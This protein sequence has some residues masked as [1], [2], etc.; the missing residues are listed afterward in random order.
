MVD[1]EHGRHRPGRRR[2]RGAARASCTTCSTTGGSRSSRASRPTRRPGPQRQRRHRGGRARRRAG[3]REARRAHRRRGAL[4]GLAGERRGRSPRSRASELTRAAADA[5]ARDGP[6]D[7]GVPAG[8]RAAASRARTSSTAGCRTR[9]CSRSSPTRASARW[10]SRHDRCGARDASPTSLV[11][12]PTADRRAAWTQ[13]YADSLMNTYG[14]PQ[15]VLVRGEGCYVW[16]ADGN[17]LPR[18]ARRHRGQRARPRPPGR[19]SSA[20]TAQVG[21]LGHV[22]N[23]FATPAADRAGRAAARRSLGAADGRVFFS[24]SGAEANEAAFKLAPARPA[25]PRSSRPRARSTAARW[26]RWR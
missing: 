26:A 3:R 22:S 12:A 4:R 1:G 10:W 17:A 21:T 25:G 18:P 15:R 7:G 11:D 14:P 13:R 9:C 5:V 16:D 20:V 8:R 2:R 24:N 23:F 6:E 19:A